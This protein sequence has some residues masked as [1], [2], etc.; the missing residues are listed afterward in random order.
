MLILD[1]AHKKQTNQVMVC[2]SP[3]ALGNGYQAVVNPE[4]LN[5]GEKFKEATC[6]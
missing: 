6:A 2:I 3:K 4:I 5:G 1:G